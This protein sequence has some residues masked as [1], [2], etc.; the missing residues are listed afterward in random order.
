M[1]KAFRGR[2]AGLSAIY[3]SDSDRVIDGWQPRVR[4]ANK[5][6]VVV[7]QG[8]GMLGR[9]DEGAIGRSGKSDRAPTCLERTALADA[10]TL[11]RDPSVTAAQPSIREQAQMAA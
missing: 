5:A 9:I 2:D 10:R 6:C 3:R 11:R 4:R 8:G 7:E 1:F